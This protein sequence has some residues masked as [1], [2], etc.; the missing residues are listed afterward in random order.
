MNHLLQAAADFPPFIGAK[1]G[2]NM[3]FYRSAC[4]QHDV[5]MLAPSG[6]A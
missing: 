1:H 2:E 5:P 6:N 3:E 4:V